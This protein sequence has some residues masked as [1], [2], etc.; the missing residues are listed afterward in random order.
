MAGMAAIMGVL[1]LKSQ[2][3]R[4]SP[5]SSREGQDRSAPQLSAAQATHRHLYT[6]LHPQ[7]RTD[8]LTFRVLPLIV[9]TTTRTS[10]NLDH[11]AFISV[12]TNPMPCVAQAY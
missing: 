5:C 12:S 9:T 8:K 7:Q 10:L 6:M 1:G 11:A 3:M 2:S 4:T